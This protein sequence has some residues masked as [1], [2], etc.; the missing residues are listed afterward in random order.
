MC[1]RLA[2]NARCM[3]D[4][5]F[6]GEPRIGHDQAPV[7]RTRHRCTP[8]GESR[9]VVQ[10]HADLDQEPRPAQ[11]GVLRFPASFTNPD[12][13]TNR[14]QDHLA[15]A[16][17]PL[18][19]RKSTAFATR[20][21]AVRARRGPP[22][23][24]RGAPRPEASSPGVR[25]DWPSGPSVSPTGSCSPSAQGRRPWGRGPIG[26][27]SPR[28]GDNRGS[29]PRDSTSTAAYLEWPQTGLIRRTGRFDSCRCNQ[30][31]PPDAMPG[32]AARAGAG[33]PRSCARS[34]GPVV[35]RQGIRLARGRRRSESGQVHQQ[36]APRTSGA[37][38]MPGACEL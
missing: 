38:S 20:G 12:R 32:P 36:G 7:Q 37:P 11:A 22:F 21:S 26:T 2:D 29:N 4:C 13:S 28:H 24:R 19:Q 25:K 33:L 27:T 10:L 15:A 30:F 17:G 18:A 34:H 23:C 14:S 5:R 1:A 6:I 3:G 31:G 8:A 16:D 9:L 35:Q